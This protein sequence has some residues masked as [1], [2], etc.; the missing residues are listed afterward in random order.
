MNFPPLARRL[1]LIALTGVVLGPGRVLAQVQ[2]TNSTATSTPSDYAI[3]GRTPHSRLWQRLQLQTNSIGTVTTNIQSYTEIA[4]GLCYLTNGQYADSVEE[5][6][7]V[8]GGAQAVQGRHKVTWALNANAPGGAVVVATPDGKQLS[9]SVVGLAWYDTSTGSNAMI[10]TLKNCTGTIVATNQVLY[11]G[12]FSNLNADIWYTYTKAGLSQ[13][14]VLRQAPAGPA[15]YG[16]SDAGSILQIYTEFFN[17]AEP[18][19]SS[20]TNGSTVDDQVLDFGEMKMG[21]GEALYLNGADAPVPAGSVRKRWVQVNGRTFL[22]ESI[23]FE[24]ISNQL[25]NLPHASNLDPGRGSVRRLAFL[26]V[27]KKWSRQIESETNSMLFAGMK[28]NQSGLVVDYNL[29]SSTNNLTL[30][31]DS[32]YFVTGTVNVSG[33]LTVEGGAVVKYTNNSGAEILI[34][35][36]VCQTAAYRPAVFTSMND[37]TAGSTIS[38]ST[39]TP[40][41]CAAAYICFNNPGTN[42]LVFKYLRFSYSA[43][44]IMGVISWFSSTPIQIWDC[45]FFDCSSAFLVP[46]LSYT[47][48]ASGF[49]IDAYNVL[50]AQC[51]TA[52]YINS[53]G[54][55]FA[56]LNAVNVT[57]D[58]ISTFMTGSSNICFATNCIF[59]GVSNTSGIAFS[60]SVVN[61]TNTGFYQT[62]GAGGYYLA[63]GSTNQ[64]AG[65]TNINAA[66]L[67]DLES[68]TTYP[69]LVFNQSW[70]TNTTNLGP[71]VP[72][73]IGN[74][75][76]LGYHYP[77]LDWA[78]NAAI[79]N[80]TV[81]VL[82]GTAVAAFGLE[83]GFWLYANGILNFEG[84]ATSPALFVKY[85][86]VQEQSNTNWCWPTVA[87]QGNLITPVQ[88]DSSSA[89]FSFTEF[90]TLSL[91]GAVYPE[92]AAMPVVLQN[93]QVF[94]ATVNLK[95]MP[96]A[97]TNCLF[98]RAAVTLS[99]LGSNI[100]ITAENNL[101]WNGS[102]TITH[103]NSGIFSVRD[104]LLDQTAFAQGSG[105]QKP[106]DVCSNN[107]YVTT[108][109]GVVPPE[110]NAVI[111]SSSPAFQSGAFGPYYYPSIFSPTNLTL[112]NAG[113]QSASAAELSYFTV[114]TN[115][116]IDGTNAV[117]I[118]FHY[119]ALGTNGLPVGP[120][121]LVAQPAS[122]VVGL[123][124]TVIFSAPSAG[125]TPL[126]YQW[127]LN[128]TNISTA[129]SSSYTVANAQ[130]ANSGTYSVC[131]TNVAGTATSSNASLTVVEVASLAPPTNYPFTSSNATLLTYSIPVSS[132]NL[133]I[134]AK[135][136]PNLPASGL[137]AVWS[138]DGQL[139]NITYISLAQPGIFTVVCQSGTS[140][141][142]NIISVFEDGD[143]EQN[144]SNTNALLLGYW[145][146]NEG[147]AGGPWV[148]SP[149][150]QPLASYGLQNPA[151][152]WTNA[153]KVDTNISANLSYPYAQANGTLNINCIN[154]AVNFWFAP[155]WNGGS[156]PGGAH[157]TLL[158][159]GDASSTNGW[160]SLFVDSAGSW[161]YFATSSNLVATTNIAVSI[162]NWTSNAWHQV[163]LNYGPDQTSLILD[164]TVA[165]IGPGVTN[166]PTI[167]QRE[168]YGFSIGSDH[169]G[170]NQMRGQLDE[171]TTYNCPIDLTP[172]IAATPTSI[173]TWATVTLRSTVNGIE[174]LSLQWQLN[175]VNLTDNT[176]I[177]GA[178]SATLTISNFQSTDLG[179]Y[180]LVASN[181]YQTV[182]CTTN[183]LMAM[184]DAQFVYWGVLSNSS[185]SL[186][187]GMPDTELAEFPNAWNIINWVGSGTV[188]G[189]F[190]Y[191]EGV[192]YDLDVG[193]ALIPG[194]MVAAT[195]SPNVTYQWL[196]NASPIPGATNSYLDPSAYIGKAGTIQLEIIGSCGTNISPPMTVQTGIEA[197]TYYAYPI[198]D[199]SALQWC[200]G[201]DYIIPHPPTIW[202]LCNYPLQYV[203][204][205][206][207]VSWVESPP[208]VKWQPSSTNVD[209]GSPL[210]LTLDVLPRSLDALGLWWNYDPTWW[211]DAPDLWLYPFLRW[212]EPFGLPVAPNYFPIIY[213]W[214]FN[215][216]PIP[217]ANGYINGWPART[218]F[219]PCA[220]KCTFANIAGCLIPTANV[221]NA[222][223][224]DCV[225][226]NAV[227][228]EIS[229]PIQVDVN[230]NLGP[231][232]VWSPVIKTQPVSQT[233]C[234]GKEVNLWVD[235]SGCK[236]ISFQWMSNGFAISSATNDSISIT[237]FYPSTNYY[238]VVVSNTNGTVTSSIATLSV[239]DCYNQSPFIVV[240]P[241]N[242]TVCEGEFLTLQVVAGGAS[243]FH[244]QWYLNDAPITN[245]VSTNWALSIGA[246]SA[247]SA[248]Q[249]YKVIVTNAYGSDSASAVVSVSALPTNL[250]VSPGPV[251]T[252]LSS[253]VTLSAAAPGAMG[254]LGYQWSFNGSSISGAT[255]SS[256]T[257]SNAEY[258]N[259]GLYSVEV[260]DS[261]GG[262][263][264]T[265]VLVQIIAP[266]STP[267]VIVSQPETQ[268]TCLG[269]PVT[270]SVAVDGS[271]P[272]AYQWQLSGTNI[273][274]ATQS[275]Y[276]A[277][278][279]NVGTNSFTVIVTNSYGAVTSLTAAITISDPTTI[280]I[281]RQPTNLTMASGGNAVFAV[282]QNGSCGVTYQWSKAGYGNL[283]SG[284]GSVIGGESNVLTLLQ[285]HTNDSGTYSVIIANGYTSVTSS[286]VVLLVTNAAL[287]PTISS[288]SNVW[289]SSIG[290]GAYGVSFAAVTNKSDAR[291]PN[292]WPFYFEIETVTNG[293]LVINGTPFAP[294]TA[295]KPNCTFNSQ[296]TMAWTPGI[297]HQGIAVPAFFVRV[298]DG[299][300]LSTN[301]VPVPIIPLP[302]TVMLGWGNNKWGSLADGNFA[303][304]PI[305]TPDLPSKAWPWTNPL[306]VSTPVQSI[307]LTNLKAFSHDPFDGGAA[308]NEAGNLLMWGS[309]TAAYGIFG[310]GVGTNEL[311]PYFTTPILVE[312]SNDTGVLAPWT[313]TVD[314]L[315]GLS[316]D[317]RHQGCG[318]K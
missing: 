82:P 303:S 302:P 282:A 37:N 183:L 201:A 65:T 202:A 8:P 127:M 285:V 184:Q 84:N 149:G 99:D 146:F 173:C 261:C 101:F 130:L 38:G 247:T 299:A 313:N 190:N 203:E 189:Q 220:Q 214:R 165:Q 135:S 197:Y 24:A 310:E 154:G 257:I 53:V 207:G 208:L 270:L 152:P 245:T 158:Q 250:Y 175:G 100:P 185:D 2:T 271:L 148:G 68:L 267:P 35:N 123:G 273:A 159:L 284:V 10:A 14:I 18:Q 39:G 153:L 298:S 5:V 126:S 294:P 16:L 31:G 300:M 137:P 93:C 289:C 204:G 94:N 97:L 227:G 209:E 83:Y 176:Q 29:L 20:I 144:C 72:R 13:D 73:N 27:P 12:A 138:L 315:A 67:A 255:A 15:S 196:A 54:S 124:A 297:S 132:S 240:P 182:T 118:G 134:V 316:R 218:S 75:L 188:E 92:D 102:L 244:Y 105:T 66:V 186:P 287:P 232:N 256:Y 147:N 216:Q 317:L 115:N 128:G 265:N 76:D 129:T 45:Q 74:Q 181:G 286:S 57:A 172:T 49:P 226:W 277:A 44:A 36:I 104:N 246:V 46:Y 40:N 51:T 150:Q 191:L 193:A 222:G 171:L 174:P 64:N 161:L 215:G 41:T 77:P 237:S 296:S 170:T 17:S 262:N 22:I 28:K 269:T 241:T 110:N 140:A 108:N 318:H 231:T 295:S 142:T 276:T 87:W 111:L 163:T 195:N 221:T 236:P 169:T 151:S 43:D 230:T 234:P 125:S 290:G 288:V 30:Q 120:P 26:D 95:F 264:S 107:A 62:V 157:G 274:G 178:N 180:A 114:M 213:Q 58:Q 42:A 1:F 239:P 145:S 78:V 223:T 166:Y 292:G 81:T 11:S 198:I 59:T 272:L 167:A 143:V 98:Q 217:N 71:V 187:Y 79:S 275:N 48:S 23:P 4:T 3:T 141:I 291:D 312:M 210:I 70:I 32:T 50:F 117:S 219:D 106:M 253:T 119:P 6:D 293:T 25:Q 47:G 21:V 194:D 34:S 279:T 80:A 168:L 156:G 266:A 225:I 133:E 258:A 88:T 33:T 233:I 268:G 211:Q 179:N 136:S 251:T 131:V 307:G 280:S 235:V 89:A 229:S 139:T 162:T 164:G 224:Y 19:A 309:M 243:T 86:T 61:S 69:P 212:V 314:V 301:Q 7:A 248:T 205:E 263:S 305:P 56:S 283:V 55:N 96:A 306:S 304:L 52:F 200:P 155:D 281:F 121:Y 90:S 85:N 192:P 242:R 103:R 160:W 63:N 206:F 91:D 199:P 228:A 311:L 112:I 122:E 113:S 254:T 308:V 116:T 238:S 177:S 278:C 249:T 109:Y 260:S 9:S 60:S 252:N 259:T